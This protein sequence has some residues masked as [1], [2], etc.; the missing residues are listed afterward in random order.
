MSNLDQCPSTIKE[1]PKQKASKA[2]LAAE[3]RSLLTTLNGRA[4][5]RSLDE[6]ADTSEFRDFL[7]REFPKGVTEVFNSTRRSFLQIMGASLALAGAATL[8]GCRRPD[9]KILSYSRTSPEDVVP[10]KPLYY[11]TSMALPGGGCEGLLVETHSGR[12]TKIEGNPMHPINRGK[13]SVLAQASVLSLYDPDRLKNP[14]FFNRARGQRLDATWDDFVKWAR[15]Y[16]PAFEKTQGEGLAIVADKKDSPSRDALRDRLLK[17]FPKAVWIAYDANEDVS[18]AEGSKIAFGTPMSD[19]ID[20]AKAAVIASFD[21][22]FLNSSSGAEPR[23]LVHAREFAST[24]RVEKTTDPMSRLYMIESGYSLTGSQADHRLRAGPARTLAA[25]VELAK[26]MLPKLGAGSSA[27]AAAVASVTVA[28]GLLSDKDRT[29]IEETAKDLM[30]SAKRGRTIVLVGPHLPA[31][32]HALGHALNAALGCTLVTMLPRSAE[33]ASDS[34]SALAKLAS[35]MKSGKV[36][37]VVCL[38]TNPAYNAPDARAFAEAFAAIEGSIALS[39]GTSETEKVATWSLNGVHSLE[40]WG[41]TIAPDGTIAPIQPMIAPLFSPA[42]EAGKAAGQGPMGEL[43]LLALIAGDVRSDGTARDAYELVRSVWRERLGSKTDAD[44]EKVWRRTLHDGLIAGSAV[45]GQTPKV[46][47]D[48]IA[49]S[50]KAL[51]VDAPATGTLEV[52]IRQG[53][54]L[55]GRNANVSW[56]QELPQ[57]GTA[58][59]WDNPALMSPKTADRLGLLPASATLESPEE[60]YTKEKYPA[61]R[62]AEFTVDG[63][64]VRCAVWILPGMADDTVL[65]TPGYGR[66]EVG[67]V[68]DGVGFDIGALRGGLGTAFGGVAC[69]VTEDLHPISSTQNHWSLEGRTAIV[70]A[71]D[72]PTFQKFGDLN[73]PHEDEVYPDSVA[74]R[75]NFAEK[76]GELSHTPPNISIYKNPYNRSAADADPSAIKMGGAGD[77][78]YKREQPP[79]F[80]T[81][82]QWGMTIDMSTCTG[83]SACTIACQAENNIPVVGKKEVAKGREMHWIRVDR[84]FAGDYFNYKDSD[85]IDYNDPQF[86][87]HQPVACVHCENAPCETVCPVNATVHGNEGHNYM[88]YNRCIGTRYCANNCPYKV[89]RYNFFEYGLHKFNGGYFGKDLIESIAP[90]RGGITGSGEHNKINPNLI[91]PRLR[92]KLDEI[93]RM[94]KNPDVTVRSRGVMEKCSYC[95][96]RTNAA[97]IEVRLQDLEWIPDG[98][99]QTACQQACPSDSIV[100]GDILDDGEYENEDGSKRKGSRVAASRLSQRSYLLLGYLN[101]RPRTSHLLKVNNPN[102]ALVDNV[103]RRNAWEHPFHGPAQGPAH[104]GEKDGSG[105]GHGSDPAAA[106]TGA[107]FD[108]RRRNEDSGY[109][110]SLSVLSAS[111]GGLA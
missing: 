36:R 81:R 84:Y 75:L 2:E 19:S 106:K 4:A 86:M 85:A 8:P 94:Q 61:G 63:R 74:G 109:A 71:V 67:L 88:V 83:C 41:D 26:F 1:G 35:D 33:S 25:L 15:G 14:V 87:F 111:N 13:S 47:S 79:A 39:V 59:V 44:F 66:T 72:L 43:E 57:H 91:P 110:L 24:R 22:D 62:V 52:V 107:F 17:K 90:D 51:K 3:R 77:P 46:N 101:T 89:R 58:V 53:W 11:A 32:A 70:R 27:L 104:G 7:E 23:G 100:F 45:K 78:L 65:L 42:P 73:K 30:D 6:V 37:S 50:V 92:E 108:P 105:T 20:F 95:I 76:L 96:Q 21:R 54:M 68:G 98:F 97:K 34:R 56:L 55:D 69:K 80:L 102:P 10:G 93:S 31:A 49:S 64:T 99:V 18:D 12:P 16:F 40:T 29:F 48:A 28:P 9:H 38:N 82:H 60:M 5:W 103:H